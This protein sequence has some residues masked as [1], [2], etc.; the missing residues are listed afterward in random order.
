[1]IILC[2]GLTGGLASG[3]TVAGDMFCK[4]GAGMVDA[5]LIGRE[6]TGPDGAAL[7][8]IQKDFGEWPF[9]AN[10][11]LDRNKLRKRVFEDRKLRRRLENI[12]H[13]MIGGRMRRA[14]HEAHQQGKPYLLLSAPLLFET[15][16]FAADCARVAVVDC[17][18]STQIRRAVARDGLPEAEARAIIASQ[19][20]REAR[21]KR[22]DDIILNDDGWDELRKQV[23]ERH[24][25]YMQLAEDAKKEKKEKT[26]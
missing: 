6:L 18:V 4:L 10:G 3:K 9:A 24:A 21:N 7:P 22:A 1:M 19:L 23:E 2:V 17:E 20:G 16:L 8:Q 5:D 25:F 26:S 14:M 15:G 13:P 12:M 11:E